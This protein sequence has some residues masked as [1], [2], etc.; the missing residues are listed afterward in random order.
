MAG[1]PVQD[2]LTPMGNYYLIR[3]KNV[4]VEG[5]RLDKVINQVKSSIEAIKTDFYTKEQSDAKYASKTD[6]NA[7]EDDIKHFK[8]WAE[9]EAAKNTIPSGAMF[10]VDEDNPENQIPKHNLLEGRDEA[11][12]HPY[13]AIEGLQAELDKKTDVAKTQTL[14]SRMNQFAKLP[15]GST[16][17]DAELA[18]IR[19]GADGKTY[20]NAGEAV[21][22][23]V[24]SLKETIADLESDLDE[25]HSI[26][27]SSNLLLKG[28]FADNTF[29]RDTNGIVE[30]LPDFVSYLDIDVSKLNGV[31]IYPKTSN[32]SVFGRSIVFYAD[33][34]DYILGN[35]PLTSEGINGIV[36][37][38]G[39]EKMSCSCNKHYT[40]GWYVGTL[41]DDL[42]VL[43]DDVRVKSEN[44]IN[45]DVITSAIV[46]DDST[47]LLN[48]LYIHEGVFVRDTNGNVENII[49]FFSIIGVDV[50]NY[51][52]KRLYSYDSNTGSGRSVVFYNESGAYISGVY[53]EKDV[54]IFVPS[55]AKTM[56]V[57]FNMIDNKHPDVFWVSDT[58]EGLHK[59]R[60]NND[61]RID[62]SNVDGLITEAVNYIENAEIHEKTFVRDTNGNIESLPTFFSVIGVD[63][64]NHVGEE[65]YSYDSDFSS[66]AGR[67]IVFYDV[68]NNYITG[69]YPESNSQS[70]VVPENAKYM[71]ASFVYA[72]RDT[73][74]YPKHYAIT[75]VSGTTQKLDESIGVDYAQIINIPQ[76]KNETYDILSNAEH[77]IA[78]INFQFDDGVV[79]DEKI[80]N[81]FKSH[82]MTCGFALLSTNNRDQEYLRYQDEGFEILSHSTDGEGMS[83]GDIDVVEEK[84]KTS[85][86]IL[87][88]KGYKIRGWVTPSSVLN[89]AFIPVMRK[90]YDYGYTV[91]YGEYVSGNPTFDKTADL[92]KLSRVSVQATTLENQKKAVD[93]AIL[94]NGFLTFYGHAADL[95]GSDNETTE[96][97][98]AL[99]EYISDKVE[100]L[101]CYVLKPSDAIDYY[102]HVRHSDYLELLK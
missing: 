11:N 52:G 62:L 57:S 74:A 47:N 23:Q 49:N 33:N 25:V 58:P 79:N 55:D 68:N 97:L 6:L 2:E 54:P 92:N 64:S 93:E 26:Y 4:D 36:I 81:I 87:T 28:T 1:I 46:K 61:I 94:N 14:E 50:T 3:A 30:S 44:I 18:D 78:T 21:R 31:T 89:E 102:F 59:K 70:I 82:N 65:L 63:I 41:S 45:T 83:R 42:F 29:V 12:A 56:S 35:Y 67:S 98:N 34:G 43:T 75:N 32:V 8:T 66:G 96:N 91:Y 76:S 99:L 38:H 10:V 85:K 73:Y 24:T 77:R 86:R 60:I 40:N 53:P 51:R 71:S 80:Y 9:Y 69:I 17:G 15:E 7:K 88:A 22:G 27:E 37:P 90:Y 100:N 19:V 101:Q 84:M 5:I 72:S 16:A 39:A 48:G 13:T 20:E 95:D